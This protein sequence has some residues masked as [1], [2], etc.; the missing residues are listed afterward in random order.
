MELNDL[1]AK[2]EELAQELA[3]AQAALP[4]HSIR[5]H[6]FQRFEEAEERLAEVERLIQEA[7]KE[8]WLPDYSGRG[9]CKA[10]SMALYISARA[11]SENWA[12]AWLMA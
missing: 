2:R 4:A 10:C 12:M 5:P 9:F 8:A 3:E 11:S 7:R 1:L 6:Q